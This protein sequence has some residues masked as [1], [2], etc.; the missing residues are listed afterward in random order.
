LGTLI[1][2]LRHGDLIPW[3]YDTDFA[4]VNQGP[5]FHARFERVLAKTVECWYVMMPNDGF[6]AVVGTR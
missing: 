3:D 4:I 1:G 2:V 6:D 5:D